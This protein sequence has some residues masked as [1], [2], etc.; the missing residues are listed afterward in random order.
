[1]KA[2][3]PSYDGPSMQQRSYLNEVFRIIWQHKGWVIAIFLTGTLLVT[4][5]SYS[6]PSIFRSTTLIVVNDQRTSGVVR[7]A[8]R[9]DSRKRLSTLSQQ[10][11][12]RTNLEQVI[13]KY[14]LEREYALA[15]ED[16]G[17]NRL[18]RLAGK[19]LLDWGLWDV[20]ED[21][22]IWAQLESWGVDVQDFQD[23]QPEDAVSQITNI[24]SPS[25]LALKES[26]ER[27]TQRMRN[28][29][30]VQLQG[31]RRD[32]F[33]VSYHSRVPQ[34]AMDVTN[35]LTSLFIESS[36]S[37][38]EQVAQDTSEVLSAELAAAAQRLAEE[39]ELLN[40]FQES[41]FGALPSQLATNQN[42]L[43]RLQVDLAAIFQEKSKIEEREILYEGQLAGLKYQ[44]NSL[45]NSHIEAKK[46]SL[47]ELKQKLELLQS[48][49]TDRYPDI[50]ITQ[51]QIEKLEKKLWRHELSSD[52]LIDED[53]LSSATPDDGIKLQ[54]TEAR[55][56]QLAIQLQLQALTTEKRTLE[57]REKQVRELIRQNERLIEATFTNEHRLS[58]LTRNYETAANN[59]QVVLGKHQKAKL[60]SD[61]EQRRQGAQFRIIDP[62][63]LPS[64]PAK[65]NRGRMILLGSLLS[66]GAGIVFVYVRE[67]LRP[68][69]FQQSEDLEMVS[70]VPVLITVPKMQSVGDRHT[71]ATI[72]MPGSVE[73]EQ[74]RILYTKIQEML[75]PGEKVIAVS[76]SIAGEGKTMTTFNLGVVLARDFD[77]KVILIEGDLKRPAFSRYGFSEG[78]GLVNILRGEAS[79]EL[80][81]TEII[82]PFPSD[83]VKG[84][85][86]LT[87]GQTVANTSSLLS[88]P[89]L[90]S[91]LKSLSEEY[92]Y[93]LI[94]TPPVLPL[95]DMNIFKSMVDGILFVVRAGKTY[96]HDVLRALN[97]LDSDRLMGF[98]LN[99]VSRSMG[100][101]YGGYYGSYYNSRYVSNSNGTGPTVPT[102]SGWNA[103]RREA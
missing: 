44:L 35:A 57:L 67:Y 15:N 93:V 53:L 5:Y 55:G 63:N 103:S 14:D 18:K 69:M 83:E 92:D 16:Q 98:V 32:A 56:S 45:A 64:K 68:R 78:T 6:L 89:Q 82:H 50:A 8:V 52:T 91:L 76:S 88:S 20:M 48:Q 31:R 34:L 97:V 59:Y 39:E 4:L 102:P 3:Y 27:L 95:S 61:L 9:A 13:K 42:K 21:K 12:S 29:I 28:D 62:A 36:L 26:F 10:I 84:L 77:K 33:T 66:G 79:L 60:T 73:A 75:S 74:Y 7:E 49:Y 72:E 25:D 38:E 43:D 71:L 24:L 1:M 30:Q 85:A 81:D 101:Y 87:A 19:A 51:G 2:H 17:L 40:K 96:Q 47:E 90:R 65:P 22:G 80:A 46:S 58:T 86:I 54:Y 94:D 11:L 41:Q 23:I 99:D 70:S 37:L 100:S